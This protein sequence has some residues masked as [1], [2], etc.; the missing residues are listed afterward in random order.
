M[1][2]TD[3]EI[4]SYLN[5][6]QLLS[7]LLVKFSSKKFVI[8]QLTH[9]NRAG[10]E[11]TLLLIITESLGPKLFVVGGLQ[12]FGRFRPRLDNT[13]SHRPIIHSN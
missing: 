11:T 3:T 2:A 9:I 4:L 7:T 10:V 1:H 5:S 13:M 12:P 8:N 6:S